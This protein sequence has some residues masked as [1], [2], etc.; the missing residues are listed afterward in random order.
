MFGDRKKDRDL[1]RLDREFH[2]IAREIRPFE[3]QQLDESEMDLSLDE[4]FGNIETHGSSGLVMGFYSRRGIETAFERYGIFPRL[5]ERGL[6]DLHV[7]VD[8]RDSYLHKAYIYCGE[9]CRSDTT[10]VELFVRRVSSPEERDF[11]ADIRRGGS[12][13][14]A[15]EWLCLQNPFAPF[16]PDRPALPGQRY[17]GL[18]IGPE[19]MEIVQIMAERLGLA[20][21]VTHPMH[22]HNA[23]LY[24]VRYHFIDPLV[25]GHLLALIRFMG[26]LPLSEVSWAVHLGAVLEARDDEEE[27]APV[28]LAWQGREQIFPINR[29][30]ARWFESSQWRRERDR[31]LVDRQFRF[32]RDLFE[33]RKHT[34]AEYQASI[35]KTLRG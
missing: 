29:G 25:E 28:S 27:E 34:S 8:T 20:G 24:Q 19:I 10:L 9:E 2:K 15:V 32:D 17:P 26:G 5:R 4:V 11:R 21:I 14:L 18:G 12:D 35:G 7:A 3:L 23:A 31:A 22:F 6:K 33:V 1:E 13:F 30:V 16:R